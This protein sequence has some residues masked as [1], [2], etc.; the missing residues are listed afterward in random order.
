MSTDICIIARH[1]I[2]PD[3]DFVQATETLWDFENY[4]G[5]YEKYWLILECRNGIEW[6]LPFEDPINDFMI[7]SDET[8]EPIE[9]FTLMLHEPVPNSVSLQDRV[10]WWY[11]VQMKDHE[12]SLEFY[13]RKAQFYE[14]YR[15]KDINDMPDGGWEEDLLLPVEIKESEEV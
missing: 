1:R 3:M 12:S 4:G 6:Y 15:Y 5:F 13:I 7:Q 10:I 2:S 14:L 8:I 11:A 9:D